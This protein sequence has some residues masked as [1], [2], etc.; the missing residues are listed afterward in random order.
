MMNT[1]VIFLS[2][3]NFHQESIF[4]FLQLGSIISVVGGDV[5]SFAVKAML[6]YVC[7][8]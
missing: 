3:S 8:F 1:V 5:M 4:Q 2:I 7:Q 6:A